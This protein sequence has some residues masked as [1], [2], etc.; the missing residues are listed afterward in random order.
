MPFKIINDRFSYDVGPA[1]QP[2]GAL[3]SDPPPTNTIDG[4]PKPTDTTGWDIAKET[5][6]TLAQYLSRL[7]LGLEGA[8]PHPNDYPIDYSDG[9]VYAGDAST[10]TPAGTPAPLTDGE[11]RRRFAQDRTGFAKGSEGLRTTTTAK[12]II[13][14]LG[15]KNDG[16]SPINGNT[17]LP[18]WPT[19][20]KALGGRPKYVAAVLSQ[21]RFGA[22]SQF[23]D[24]PALTL[25]DEQYDDKGISKSHKVSLEQLATVGTT[26]SLRSTLEVKSTEASL[27][28]RSAAAEAASLIPSTNQLLV[29]R[30]APDILAAKNVLEAFTQDPVQS[31]PVP[32][33]AMISISPG[34]SWGQ[35][36]NVYDQFSG[37]SA[38]G[39]IALSTALTTALL[40]TLSGFYVLLGGVVDKLAAGIIAAPKDRAGR[41][42]LGSYLN[43]PG[44][45]N[46][47]ANKLL[48]IASLGI[49]PTRFPLARCV[50]VGAGAFFGFGDLSDLSLETITQGFTGIVQSPGYNAIL[51]RNII[52]SG[53]VIAERVAALAGANG[54][55]VGAG[56]IDILEF[57]RSS[58]IVSAISIFARIG[59]IIL[60]H[61]EK[62]PAIA[63]IGNVFSAVELGTS[64]DLPNTSVTKSRLSDTLKLAWSGNRS[65]ALYLVPD[66]LQ[67]DQLANHIGGP[68][69][70]GKY[71]RTKIAASGEK[72][73]TRIN[74]DVVSATESFLDS[75]Y[76]PFYFHDLRTNEIV[77]FHAFLSSFT[78]DF[79]VEWESTEGYGRIEP[80]KIYKGTQRRLSL[81]FYIVSTSPE[82]FDE[83]WVKINKLVTL[84]Y[85]QYTQGKTMFS[86]KDGSYTFTQPFSQLIGASPVIRL[87]LGDMVRSNYSKF[88]LMRLFGYGDKMKLKNGS[89]IVEIKYL[90]ALEDQS[91]KIKNAASDAANSLTS[92]FTFYIPPGVWPRDPGIAGALGFGSFD[93]L[94]QNANVLD[95]TKFASSTSFV[96]KITNV[97]NADGLAVCQ[98]KLNSADNEINEYDRQTFGKGGNALSGEAIEDGSYRIP[99]NLL[100]LS[101]ASYFKMI[102]DAEDNGSFGD[103]ATS[104]D[105]LTAL[106]DFFSPENNAL[107][108]SFESVGGK[109]LGGVIE[110]MGF[111]EFERLPWEI[112]NGSKA[113]MMCKVSLSFHPIHDI[114]PGL[115]HNGFNRAPIYPVGRFMNPTGDAKDGRLSAA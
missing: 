88:S 105:Q 64:D 35:L 115:D 19:D 61:H 30:I 17:L 43:T 114:A 45:Q 18:D 37:L 1:D 85:P 109:G 10:R 67:S 32:D 28:P 89:D 92:D 113:P 99:F 51:A 22:L 15:L 56:I 55:A 82:D 31:Y 69:I 98:V 57:V 111:G 49:A 25:Y 107:V 9:N 8:A 53:Q 7:T 24:D 42:T 62:I 21:N 103:N 39:M 96:V 27:D 33:T 83:M 77:S 80:V 90:K 94:S 6:L 65:P 5:K 95:T 44:Q 47:V 66:N 12:P 16:A 71:S 72:S 29:Q 34:G 46:N 52:R 112:D 70:V 106:N 110:S 79:N 3:P 38:V 54:V 23:K 26:L 63:G 87:R 40:A 58:K 73:E 48:N 78:D 11:N 76:M 86:D 41:Y 81:S 101:R 84:L 100:V 20:P 68:G 13:Q 102:A 50:S 74:A 59:D 60:S 75:E 91:S 93:Q 108:K 2:G 4:D 14:T 36:N 97:K 104:T